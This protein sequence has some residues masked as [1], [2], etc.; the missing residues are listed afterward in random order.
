V[1]F[2]LAW[3]LGLL[4][5]TALERVAELLLSERNARRAVAAGGAE[6]GR[7]HY[8][9][10]VVIHAAFLA[11]CA[12]EALAFPT[13]P[14]PLAWLA[15]AGAL[16]AQGLRWWAVASL[17]PRWSTRVVV[18][19]GAPPVTAGPYR[20]L[21]HPNYLAVVVEVAC[22]PL[23]FGSWR[24]ALVFSAL[25]AVLL[26]VRIHAEERALGPA[27]EEAFRGRPRLVPQAGRG[28]RR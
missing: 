13:P 12:A 20:W 6:H 4:A 18:V 11:A 26:R 9:A 1:T 10:M 27:W 15:L 25:N 21:R 17:G 16:L 28:G 3:Y 8:P 23:A 22:L 19:P 14:P 2:P 24:T 7:G 5:L